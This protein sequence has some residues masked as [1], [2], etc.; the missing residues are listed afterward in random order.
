MRIPIGCTFSDM[1]KFTM[2]AIGYICYIPPCALLTSPLSYSQ[3][4]LPYSFPILSYSQK[5]RIQSLFF[6]I[7]IGVKIIPLYCNQALMPLQD[8]NATST[9]KQNGPLNVT[10]CACKAYDTPSGAFCAT[11][12]CNNFP[13]C[14]QCNLI[15]L[16][17]QID[18]S[19]SSN[20]KSNYFFPSPNDH[21]RHA[22][23]TDIENH[24]FTCLGPCTGGTYCQDCISMDDPYL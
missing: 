1:D 11:N 17:D 20:C 15:T 12:S 21:D 9:E 13:T 5:S 7:L 10:E 19:I 3:F 2:L 24:A 14:Q 23:C 8:D 16:G 22:L 4:D 18:T 6:E